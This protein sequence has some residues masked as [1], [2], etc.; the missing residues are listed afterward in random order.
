V[1]S[2]GDLLCLKLIG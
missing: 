1:I 2:Y